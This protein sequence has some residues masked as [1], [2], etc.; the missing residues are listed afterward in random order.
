LL[1]GFNIPRGGVRYLGYVLR[2]FV[3]TVTRGLA[4]GRECGGRGKA[5][6]SQPIT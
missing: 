1:Q 4:V 2:H 5:R 3:G 6:G